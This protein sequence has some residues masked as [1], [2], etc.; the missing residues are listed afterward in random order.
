[1]GKHRQHRH[2]AEI[3]ADAARLVARYLLFTTITCS[4]S[5]LALASDRTGSERGS[6]SC[7]AGRAED[8]KIQLRVGLEHRAAD[9]PP[10]GAGRLHHHPRRSGAHHGPQEID[11]EDAHGGKR[12]R[13]SHS[14]Y[15]IVV[16]H[17]DDGRAG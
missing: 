4:Q 8:G 9:D 6:G 1:M 15:A 2:T 17:V 11:A 3:L 13:R 7:R 5:Q 16:L 10:C 12:H 14:A